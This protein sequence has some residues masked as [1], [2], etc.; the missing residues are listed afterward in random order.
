MSAPTGRIFD[1]SRG[2]VDD[3]PGLRTVVYLKG[4]KLD[5]PWCHNPEGKSFAPQI[6]LSDARCIACEA[7]ASAC[8]RDWPFGVTDA[9]RDGCDRCARCVAACPSGARQ[10][11]GRD[12]AADELVRELAVDDV[13]FAGTGGGVTFS[14]GEPLLQHTFVLSCARALRAKGVHVAVETAG[15]WARSIAAEVAGGVDLVL[16]DLK[17]AD[18]SRMTAALG[19]GAALVLPNLSAL[20]ASEVELEL[21]VTLIPGFNDSPADLDTLV[22]WLTRAPRVPPIRL[23]P[24]HRMATAKH[25]LH[26]TVYPYAPVT[27]PAR[28]DC[29]RAASLL[30]AR[31]LPVTPEVP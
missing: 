21:R 6:S 2:C 17:H 7:C 8:P 26:G 15:L 29:A 4:C 31:G 30:A 1:V 28:A 13:F 9:W 18:P 3:G 23:V 12:V 24:F 20:L 5:C 14:G 16:F 19:R 11:V 10:L 27:P 25:T 22:R